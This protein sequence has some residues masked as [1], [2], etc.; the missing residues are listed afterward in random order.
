MWE[1][2]GHFVR[3][4]LDPK[5]LTLMVH[6]RTKKLNKNELGSVLAKS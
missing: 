2:G 4:D 1:G 3:P 5:C 6:Q